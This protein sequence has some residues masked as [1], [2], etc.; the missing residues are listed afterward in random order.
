[1]YAGAAI[2]TA[3]L[4]AGAVWRFMP[5]H[6]PPGQA[7]LATISA[8]GDLSGTFNGSAGGVRVLVLLSPT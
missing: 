3:T 6:T 7:P 5:R 1:L 4:I 8:V 2:L